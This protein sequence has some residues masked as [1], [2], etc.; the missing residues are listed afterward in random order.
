MHLDPLAL[1][2]VH[3][4]LLYERDEARLL[5]RSRDVSLPTPF[6]HLTRTTGGNLWLLSAA[7]L[8]QERSELV[9]ALSQ[10]PVIGDL[11]DMED[12]PPV[13]RG[14]RALLAAKSARLMD[15]RGPVFTFPDPLPL[16]T[17]NGEILQEPHKALTVP[18]LAWI[19]EATPAL[20]PL[21][22]TRNAMGEI[23]AVC[24]SARSTATAVAAGVET[25]P[26]YRGRGLAGDVVL[27]WAAAVRAED[28][29]PMYGTEWTNH[30]SRAVAR[31]LGLV[32]WGEDCYFFQP[33]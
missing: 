27:C 31:K 6:L 11:N 19:R 22:V 8:E 10:E 30:A 15:Y 26:D 4:D 32:L 20:H 3:L 12:R 28:R 29:L 21:S 14:V 33:Q 16:T 24:H 25:A 2:A 17:G 9:E 13:L 18:E 1:A 5:F 23:V 7:L